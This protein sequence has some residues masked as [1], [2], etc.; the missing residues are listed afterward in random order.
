MSE[1]YWWVVLC[2]VEMK[3][4]DTAIETDSLI[5]VKMSESQNIRK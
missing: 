4:G 2:R 5:L 3:M 1:I